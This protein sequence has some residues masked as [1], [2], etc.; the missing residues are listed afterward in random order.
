M[1]VRDQ[2]VKILCQSSERLTN[3]ELDLYTS[4]IINR[5]SIDENTNSPL[6]VTT[7]NIVKMIVKDIEESKRSENLA[8]ERIRETEKRI[9][10][11]ERRMRADEDRER[12]D[13]RNKPDIVK[14]LS[15]GVDRSGDGIKRPDLVQL[16]GD[17]LNLLTYNNVKYP[18]LC[19]HETNNHKEYE[20]NYDFWEDALRGNLVE[21]IEVNLRSF[22]LMQWLPSSPGRYYTPKA[23]RERQNAER[24]LTRR[25]R[26][27][28]YLPSGKEAM[29]L[30]GIG[31][32][33]LGARKFDSETIYLLGA[34]SNGSSHQGIPVMV[35]DREYQKVI[36]HLQKGGCL[37]NMEGYLRVFSANEIPIQYDRQIPK[38]A[39]FIENINAIK[40]SQ[41][42]I[43]S[44]GVTY[45]LHDSYRGTDKSWSFCSFDPT[46]D[47]VSSAAQWLEEYALR[48]SG[49]SEILS[50]F[51]EYYQ[52]FSNDSVEFP[53][54]Q[55]VKG[56]VDF[57]RI[58][59]Y[60]RDL[61]F[62]VNLN[63]QSLIMGSN[64]HVQNNNAGAVGDGAH[65]DGNTIIIN[66]EQKQNLA[67]DAAE[68]LN[69]LK[70]LEQ[71]NPTAIET[72]Q[73]AYVNDETTPNFKRRVAGAFQASGETAIDEFILENKYLKVAKA[74]VKGWL[75]PSG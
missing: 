74:A 72:E 23:I 28:E 38:Y 57:S 27:Q 2:I 6:D 10:E 58:R 35:P 67:K 20:N 73:V 4:R 68:I 34:S 53:V 44:V 19:Q 48:H 33:R 61:G 22:H 13:D 15:R 5:L 12:N 9:R 69:L 1:N 21:G 36:S 31:S 45:T 60:Q 24:H 62:E 49:K 56:N 32:V 37:A 65:A 71:T 52:H 11:K 8:S 29:F 25:G 55:I 39:I 43:V 40:P 59:R 41:N 50:D 14:I 64:Y 63:I 51:D 75:Q 42:L 16:L 47:D 7:T 30:G 70:S 18:E 46:R 66:S 17:A 3:S 54:S 26:H